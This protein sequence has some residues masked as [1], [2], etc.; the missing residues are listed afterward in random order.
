MN[1]SYAIVSPVTAQGASLWTLDLLL[2]SNTRAAVGARCC[3]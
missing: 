3:T 2:G 1:A